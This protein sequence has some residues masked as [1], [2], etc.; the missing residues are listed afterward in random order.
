MAFSQIGKGQP[1]PSSAVYSV[2]CMRARFLG[3][4]A[5]GSMGRQEEE[6]G[7]RE[8]KADELKVTRSDDA[9]VRICVG[10]S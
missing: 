6:G 3:S 2:V 9:G 8:E 7:G 10:R 1:R 4:W 5:E